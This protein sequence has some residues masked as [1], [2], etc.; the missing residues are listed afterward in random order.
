MLLLH[1]ALISSCN[2]I[3]IDLPKNLLGRLQKIQNWA[4]KLIFKQSIS[5]HVTPLLKSLHWL[6][7]TARTQFKILTFVHSCI[8][9]S[10]S[11]K[12][13]SQLI[14]IKDFNRNT[15]QSKFITLIVPKTNG[16]L[17]SN[18]CFSVAGPKLWNSL[19][20]YLKCIPEKSIFTSKLKTHL[21]SKHF[22]S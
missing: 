3:C 12:Y 4:A 19:L 9:N 15:R 7:I 20:N 2:S 11:P 10:S 1:P 14:S 5:T 6:P 8:H 22:S 16:I 13:L 17:Y 21:F 18:R